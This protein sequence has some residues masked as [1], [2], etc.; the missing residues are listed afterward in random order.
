[1]YEQI[2]TLLTT[3]I[4]NNNLTTYVYADF[5]CQGIATIFCGLVVALPFIILWRIIR[6]LI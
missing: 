5:F 6:R 2:Y 4:F 3:A 1:M